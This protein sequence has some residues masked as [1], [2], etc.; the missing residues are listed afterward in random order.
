MR[1]LHVLTYILAITLALAQSCKTNHRCAG[2]YSFDNPVW[3]PVSSQ[4]K[5]LISKL[6]VV[7]PAKR[8]TS[9]QAR[10]WVPHACT[11]RTQVARAVFAC[12]TPPTDTPMHTHTRMH[13]HRSHHQCYGTQVLRHSWVCKCDEGECEALPDA[14]LLMRVA[15]PR[16][17]AGEA[18]LVDRILSVRLEWCSTA[19]PLAVGSAC[20]SLRTTGTT[21]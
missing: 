6:L 13:A 1:V 20:V 4:A 18:P 16:A 7:D 8:L 21:S 19:Q 14:A 11:V 17:H 2:R 12:C 5:D 3:R 10:A 9:A 15:I